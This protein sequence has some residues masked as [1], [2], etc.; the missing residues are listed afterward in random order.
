VIHLEIKTELDVVATEIKSIE[1][2]YKEAEWE[3]EVKMQKMVYLEKEREHLFE[4]FHRL[5]YEFH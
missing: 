5:V 3:H 2:G 4:E 1:G